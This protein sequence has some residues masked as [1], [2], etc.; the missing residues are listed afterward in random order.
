MSIVTVASTGNIAIDEA[1]LQILRNW[2]V[3]NKKTNNGVV[4][5]AAIQEHKVFIA[6]GSGME[7]AVPDIVAKQ[8]IENEI[9]PNF[10][11]GNYY[12]GFDA[13]AD[14]VIQAAA[15]TYKAPEGYGQRGQHNSNGGSI[16]GLI[17]LAV[18]ILVVISRGGGGRG[19]MMNNSGFFPW[20]IL[21]MLTNRGGGGW[22][23]GGGGGGGG[24][25]GGFG[26]GGGGGGGA[27]GSW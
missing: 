12:R 22:S 4:I 26:G 27:G 23:G 11:T 16:F 10:K 1:A 5:L 21:S 17:I 25:F 14:A 15:G 20:M 8:I 19:G 6:T 2:G 7:S 9:V 24:G 3:G 13:A 18:I